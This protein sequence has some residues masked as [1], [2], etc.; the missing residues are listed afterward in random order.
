MAKGGSGGA[1]LWRAVRPAC[2]LPHTT[3]L[4]RPPGLQLPRHPTPTARRR[5]MPPEPLWTVGEKGV[6]HPV[7]SM[8]YR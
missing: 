8:E 5:P 3:R 7:K 2:G 4:R 6:L 1:G